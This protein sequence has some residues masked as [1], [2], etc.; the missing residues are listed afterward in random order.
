MAKF[1]DLSIFG[2]LLAFAGG[3]GGFILVISYFTYIETTALEDRDNARLVEIHMLEARR[4][5]KD[6]LMRND[7]K[8]VD[9]VHNAV[10]LVIENASAFSDH[11]EGKD[12]LIAINDYNDAF[13]QVVQKTEALGLNEKLGARGALRSSVHNIEDI[14]NAANKLDIKVEMLMARRSEK[15]FLMRKDDKYIE[16]VEKAVY[17]IINYSNASN[18]RLSDK[19]Q[20]ESLANDYL[21]KFTLATTLIKERDE[22]IEAMREAVHKI[23]PVVENIIAE[24]EEE[25]AFYGVVL[26]IAIVASLILALSLSILLA[27]K[28]SKPVIQLK[29][30]AQKFGTGNFN[31]LLNNNSKDEIGELSRSFSNAIAL[32]K[33]SNDAL[34]EEKKS[35]EKKVEIAV[36]ES[37]E[38]KE[39]L[40]E[41]VQQIL[42]KMND[43]SQG[44]LTVSLAVNSDDEIGKLFNGFNTVVAKINKTILQINEAVDATVSAS[45]EISSSTEQMAAGAQE[46][47]SQTTEIATAVEEM[48]STI[49]HT[50]Q[51]V[52]SAAA[53]SKS[54]N[55]QAL[56]GVDKVGESIEGMTQIV[57]STKN[58]G[59]IISSLSG[60]TD[61][62]GEITQVIDD[63]ADQTNLLALNAAIEAARAGEQGRGFAVV[64]DE[65]RK[66]AERTTKATKEIAETIKAIQVEA[67][68]ADDSMGEATTVVENGMRLTNEVAEVLTNILEGTKEVSSQFDQIAAASEEQSTASDEISKSIE[69]IRSVSEES[70][71]GVQQ[72][73]A[74]TED[75]S[76]LTENLKELVNAFK[77]NKSV[78]SQQLYLT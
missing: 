6:F 18:I 48:T 1:E 75:L 74:S 10:Q 42:N 77:V 53:I 73:A 59:E 61:Q 69:M 50:T 58:T 67:K 11:G 52:S 55:E 63:I 33:E 60:K 70:A 36:K 57:Q 68:E 30:A 41:S 24:H 45:S 3:I 15:D 56:M 8:Y 64:A 22:D 14:V 9:K 26:I 65:V 28:I 27:K 17:N 16:R 34:E 40:S 32:V 47:S 25:A 51:N 35:V 12:L 54:S 37:E 19:T 46:Q 7:M 5:E 78:S 76:R 44:D 21:Q 2:K 39:Y 20:I 23:E 72:I 29:E 49:M 43:F 31:I 38:Q 66:L 4:S 62:I 13:S 71:R